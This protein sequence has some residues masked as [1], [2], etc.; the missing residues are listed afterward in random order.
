MGSRQTPDPSW[1]TL[2]PSP[3]KLSSDCHNHSIPR[4]LMLSGSGDKTSPLVYDAPGWQSLAECQPIPTVA[5][6]P[7]SST[8]VRLDMVE[9]PPEANPTRDTTTTT[10]SSEDTPGPRPFSARPTSSEE[11]FFGARPEPMPSPGETSA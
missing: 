10:Q 6:P 7:N 3:P 2:P 5:R 1:R 9:A 11:F 4:P 8:P